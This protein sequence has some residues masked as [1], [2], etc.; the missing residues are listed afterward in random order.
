MADR[1]APKYVPLD[2]LLEHALNPEHANRTVAGAYAT[3]A[4]LAALHRNDV[5]AAE[6]VINDCDPA[7][8]I[9]GLAGAWLELVRY[10]GLDAEELLSQMRDAMNVPNGGR[11][12]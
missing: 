6:L 1:T 11:R 4:V 12:G 8:T 9:A 3:V 2:E 7:P 5:K 10:A